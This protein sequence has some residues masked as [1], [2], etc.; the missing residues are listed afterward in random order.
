MSDPYDWRE[1]ALIAT[2]IVNLG[3]AVYSLV[4][5]LRL[6]VL[7]GK[8]KCYRLI[9]ALAYA[10]YIILEADWLTRGLYHAASWVPI[11]WN[12]LDGTWMLIAPQIM[13]LRMC[14][15]DQ[16]DRQFCDTRRVDRQLKETLE[17]A[18]QASRDAAQ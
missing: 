18:S 16:A 1:V 12:I 8:A 6:Q 2:G 10:L 9:V 11:A 4:M 17:K 3:L 14:V 13:R 7:P 15:G 5:V